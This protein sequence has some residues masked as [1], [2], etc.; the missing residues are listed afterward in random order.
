MISFDLSQQHLELLGFSRRASDSIGGEMDENDAANQVASLLIRAA[1]PDPAAQEPLLISADLDGSRT[2]DDAT[3]AAFIDRPMNSRIHPWIVRAEIALSKIPGVVL[4]TSTGGP[5][6]RVLHVLNESFALG[7][8]TISASYGTEIARFT[9]SSF[10]TTRHPRTHA[11]R[12]TLL[13]AC[14]YVANS[15]TCAAKGP[16]LSTDVSHDACML[17]EIK[18]NQVTFHHPR[19]PEGERLF[20]ACGDAL[21]AFLSD[22]P[23]VGDGDMRFAL[24][25]GSGIWELTI[26][27]GCDKG[28]VLRDEINDEKA[29]NAVII[30]DDL[31]DLPA[32]HTLQ[33][34]TDSGDLAQSLSIAIATDDSYSDAFRTT[35]PEITTRS[36]VVIHGRAVPGEASAEPPGDPA[37]HHLGEHSPQGALGLLLTQAIKIAAKQEPNLFPQEVFDSLAT[38]VTALEI[39]NPRRKYSFPET[40]HMSF[41]SRRQAAP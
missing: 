28:T 12:A 4:H 30:V 11:L 37:L 16:V 32:L 5:L 8:A 24:L 21:A 13:E 26:D 27:L 36:D 6:P 39:L 33:A 19:T 3:G 2:Y 18:P 25:P 23:H 17:I 1:T 14:Q 38:P 29:V 35:P 22:A 10:A 34:L 15:M 41:S 7:L 9:T 31:G 40:P 20:A